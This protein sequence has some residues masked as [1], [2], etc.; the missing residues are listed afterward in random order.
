VLTLVEQLFMLQLGILH[1]C[2]TSQPETETKV[3]LEPLAYVP[4]PY[5]TRP[6]KWRTWRIR[7]ITNTDP[8]YRKQDDQEIVLDVFTE[9]ADDVSSQFSNF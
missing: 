7:S 3:V 1:I 8:T 4:P 5:T 6:D 2:V 9:R